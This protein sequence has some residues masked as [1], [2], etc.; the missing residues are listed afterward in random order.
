M[1]RVL[2]EQIIQYPQKGEIMTPPFLLAP[3]PSLPSRY[4]FAL[5]SNFV[6]ERV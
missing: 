3:I 2:P 5:L 1:H 4:C 6:K